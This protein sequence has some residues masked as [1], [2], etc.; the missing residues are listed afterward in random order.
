MDFL[1]RLFRKIVYVKEL[2]TILE[3]EEKIVNEWHSK[4]AYNTKRIAPSLS[5]N[6]N[7]SISE[8]NAILKDM[9]FHVKKLNSELRKL[10]EIRRILIKSENELP[11][12]QRKVVAKLRKKLDINPVK[13]KKLKEQI[14]RDKDLTTSSFDWKNYNKLWDELV[15][16]EVDFWKHLSEE[17]QE[18]KE[19]INKERD[20]IAQLKRISKKFLD[21]LDFNDPNYWYHLTDYFD[22]KIYNEYIKL[23]QG[24]WKTFNRNNDENENREFYENM[25]DESKI[26]FTSVISRCES[27]LD[28]F[29]RTSNLLE[30]VDA[31]LNQ[32]KP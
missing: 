15:V 11:K 29:K 5:T 14:L 9:W 26:L 2:R 10:E 4:W 20:K 28:F 32:I 23:S 8:E 21:R 22:S 27:I 19:N 18:I 1:K 16:D 12:A 31:R 6:G 17:T 24:S 13:N 25:K 3:E 30:D 7:D